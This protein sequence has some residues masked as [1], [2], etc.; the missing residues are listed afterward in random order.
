[1]RSFRQDEER[2]D[3]PSARRRRRRRVSFQPVSH[4]AACVTVTNNYRGLT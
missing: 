1:M 4:R 3:L 2:K